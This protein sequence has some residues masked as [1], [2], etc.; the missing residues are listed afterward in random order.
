MQRNGLPME[1]MNHDYDSKVILVENRESDVGL[2]ITNQSRQGVI[3]GIDRKIIL[4]AV[5]F[6]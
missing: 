3:P 1:K 2:T 4:N 6:K 5:K